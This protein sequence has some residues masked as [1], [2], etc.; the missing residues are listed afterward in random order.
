MH[1]STKSKKSYHAFPVVHSRQILL[2]LLAHVEIHVVVFEGAESLDDYVVALV[3][4]VLVRFQ[5]GGNFPDGNVYI[6]PVSK[7]TENELKTKK[8]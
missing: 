7:V 2:K 8:Q 3:N 6:W 1:L 5:Q 4:D